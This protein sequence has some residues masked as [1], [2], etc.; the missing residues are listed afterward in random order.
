MKSL[1]LSK[2]A[3]NKLSR[4]INFDNLVINLGSNLFGPYNPV[5]AHLYI[6]YHSSFPYPYLVSFQ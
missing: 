2:A 5:I 1:K 3:A 4:T 6:A